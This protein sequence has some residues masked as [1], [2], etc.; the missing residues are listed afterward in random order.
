MVAF[1]S[2]PENKFDNVEPETHGNTV[3]FLRSG[4]YLGCTDCGGRYP[5]EYHVQVGCN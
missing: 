3:I 2:Q 1:L 5:I 4:T